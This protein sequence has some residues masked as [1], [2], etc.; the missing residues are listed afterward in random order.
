MS[1][2]HFRKLLHCCDSSVPQI[3]GNLKKVL[4]IFFLTATWL[5]HSQFWAIIE[6]TGSLTRCQSLRFTFSASRSTGASWPGWAPKPG[7]APS[8]V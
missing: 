7:Q 5:P 4:G 3:L 6:G 1:Q 2:V 8:G